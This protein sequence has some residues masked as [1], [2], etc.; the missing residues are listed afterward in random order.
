ML[1]FSGLI[2]MILLNAICLNRILL[3]NKI[4]KI[5][6]YLSSFIFVICS[7]PLIHLLNY[8]AFTIATFLFILIYNEMIQFNNVMEG[9][10]GVFKTGLFLGLIIMID[11]NTIFLYPI[12]LFALLHYRQFNGK[13]FLIQLIGV[14]YPLMF[15]YILGG[16]DYIN[17]SL[18][19]AQNPSFETIYSYFKMYPVF[20]LIILTVLLL[21]LYELFNNYYKKNEKAKGGFKILLVIA[22][23]ILIH[24]LFSKS[25]K[26]LGFLIMPITIIITNYLLYTK[27]KKFRTFL[28]G[29]LIVSFMFEIF[30]L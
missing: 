27:H 2:F 30:Y 9:A 26:L 12:I 20:L 15:Y 19:Y 23:T 3:I 8:W 14:L 1:K 17:T 11:Y 6:S 25:L 7:L 22:L 16:F 10:K 21:S 13:N 5:P 18:L 24:A 28:L 4:I 29:L